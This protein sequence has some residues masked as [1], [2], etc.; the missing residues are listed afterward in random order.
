MS[1]NDCSD[2]AGI[3]PTAPPHPVFVLVENHELEKARAV[4]RRARHTNAALVLDGGGRK[5]L[6]GRLMSQDDEESRRKQDT[7][8]RCG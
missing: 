1:F 5:S 7:D 2:A 6:G 3:I 4:M 8:E